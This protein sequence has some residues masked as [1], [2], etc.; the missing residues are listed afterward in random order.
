MQVPA[1]E[2]LAQI[3][4]RK[5]QA[6]DRKPL[7]V[8][9]SENA[10]EYVVRAASRPA[11]ASAEHN[12]TFLKRLMPVLSGLAAQLV[13]LWSKD[14]PIVQPAELRK[15]LDTVFA[16]TR[17]PSLTLA[18]GAC[19][20]WSSLLK[21]DQLAKEPVCVEFVP[22]LIEAIAPKVIKLP[23]PTVRSVELNERPEGYAALDY[24]SDE[25]YTIFFHRSRTTILE[26]VRLATLMAPLVTFAYCE[27]WLIV[28]LAKAAQEA[29][30]QAA[31][32]RTAIVCRVQDPVY[33][34]WEALVSVLDS[35]LSRILLVAERP[36]V[37]SGLRLLEQTLKVESR[38]PL[39]QSI[40]L[41]CISSLFVFLSMSSCQ[42]TAGN[43]VA[44]SGVSLLPRVLEK[45][46]AALVSGKNG[47]GA[48]AAGTEPTWQQLAAEKN[49]RRHSAAL[50]VRLG[51]KYPL[52]LLPVFDQIHSSVQS[53]QRQPDQLRRNECAMLREALLVIS[54]HFC[55]YERQSAFVLD[56][57]R[58]SA[59]EWHSLSASL[60]TGC[61]L[62]AFIAIDRAPPV[63][64]DTQNLH[65]L[66][67]AVGQVLGVVRRCSWPDDPDR[68]TRG[69]FVV[70]LTESGNPIYRNPA[71]VHVVPL[72]P[73]ILALLRVQN[74]LFAAE[75][76][77]CIHPA[78]RSVLGM[79][80][81]EKRTL[82][83]VSP[84]LVDPMDPEHR[85]P[86]GVP[87]KV[88]GQLGQLFDNCYYLM[89]AAGPALG[90]DLYQLPGIANALVTSVFGGLEYVPDYRV[91]PIVRVFLKPFVYSCPPAC[92]ESVLLPIWAHVAPRMLQRLTLR[93]AYIGELYESGELGD[94]VNDTQEVFEDMLNRTLTR[95]Y[96]DV[97]KVALV[98]GALTDGS[99]AGMVGASSVQDVNGMEHDDQSLDSPHNVTRASQSAMAAEVISELGGRLLRCEATCT[100]LVITVLR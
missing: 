63:D 82:M 40:V 90:R 28:R 25:E 62:V 89:G 32:P 85:R 19:L 35:V 72:L 33:V 16:L 55:D 100:P 34:E 9:F 43:C 42:I 11:S 26:I 47:S 97:I 84:V 21:H 4:N 79:M 51:I 2:C 66:M 13:A 86:V 5:G 56:V 70:A 15:Y 3:V 6:K 27:Q 53:L 98:G 38:D 14:E 7:T 41:S 46:F 61:D 23:Y 94:D 74:E 64:A 60:K 73:H 1:A 44:M 17:H 20:I 93:W 10:I 30:A 31:A 58:D 36:S 29:Q 49:L 12:Y 8:L 48:A 71:A 88:Q 24:D 68:A 91:R 57:M 78:F 92:Y 95:E 18:H 22:Q 59:A 65:R 76:V 99:S 54:N 81:S 80:E 69:G 45:I 87:I 77:S 67:N 52:L 37:S 50:M 39:V 75:T 96:L 83:G